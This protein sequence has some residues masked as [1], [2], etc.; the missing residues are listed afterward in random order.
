MHLA[1]RSCPGYPELRKD[2]WMNPPPH[3]LL[4]E[5]GH[6]FCPSCFSFMVC[7]PEKAN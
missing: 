6:Y 1:E 3:S 7:K 2:F 5:E 4:F